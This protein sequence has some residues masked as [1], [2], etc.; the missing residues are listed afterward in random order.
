M[1]RLTKALVLALALAALTGS[2]GSAEPS[3]IFSEDFDDG[4]WTSN[5][6]WTASPA[7]PSVAISGEQFASGPY[8][9]KIDA[10]NASGA[11]RGPSGLRTFDQP[12]ACTFNL[13][14]EAIPEEGIPWCL[15]DSSG[16]VVALIFLLPGGRVELTTWKA[17]GGY[18]K[19]AVPQPLSYGLWHSFR[20]TYDGSTQALF[21]DGAAGPCASVAL[22]F[23]AAPT[24]ISVG[25]FQL[26]H[27][28]TYYVD[29]ITIS[30][31]STQQGPPGRVYVQFCSDTSTGG[32][33][34]SQNP[35]KFPSADESY[36]SPTG[37]AARVMADAYREA[38]RDSLGNPLKITWYMN[39]GSIYSCGVDT[40]PVL[41]YE[42]LE[43]NHGE[44][45]ARWG[46]EMAFHYHTWA[47]TDPDGDG[48]YQ[49]NQTPTFLECLTDF[50]A[51]IAQLLLDRAFYPSSFRSGWNWMDA[52]WELYLDQLFPYRFE[53]R[54][55][56]QGWVPYHPGAEDYRVPGGLRGWEA[57][58]D[59]IP[60]YTQMEVDDTFMLALDGVDQVVT[61]YSHLKEADFPEQIA[62]S[63]AKFAAAHERYPQVEYE[64]LTA[65][66]C[67][68]KWR[69]GSDVTPPVISV[70]ASDSGEVRTAVFSTDEEIYQT[71]PYVARKGTDGVYSRIPCEPAGPNRWSVSY[72][73]GETLQIGVAVTDWF[74]NPAVEA[75]PVPLRLGKVA[76]RATSS[77]V[78]VQWETTLPATTRLECCLMPAGDTTVIQDTSPYSPHKATFAGVLPGRVYRIRLTAE[79][80]SG[81]RVTSSDLY[82]LTD[83]AGGSVVDNVDAGFSV[84]GS[85]TTG[86]TASGR[87]GADYRYATTSLS[88]ANR[89]EWTLTAPAAGLYRV[90]AW[91]SQG[92][93]RS[94]SAPYSVI[95]RGTEIAAT[96][97]QQT[98]GGQWNPLGTFPLD[99]GEVVLVR[100]TNRAPSGYVV[101]ADAVKLEQ[102]YPL[103]HGPG[104]AKLLPD[105]EAI[106]LSGLVVSAVFEDDFY[107]QAADRSAGIRVECIGV[108]EGDRV[109]VSGE[110]ITAEGERSIADP[111]VTLE[112]GGGPPRPLHVS[113][114]QARD[115]GNGPVTAGMLVRVCGKVTDLEEGFFSLDDG[116]GPP[117]FVE[118]AR[119]SQVPAIG[120]FAVVTGV[121]GALLRNGVAFPLIRPRG[122]SDLAIELP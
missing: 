6:Y 88:G 27:T 15:M 38:L 103:V 40:T 96:V 3:V 13:F 113:S 109:T 75:L 61:L 76:V 68:L 107:A 93:N 2:V 10:N 59:Y 18:V 108:S 99:A 102:G 35:I 114:A 55:F 78:D 118:T 97:N 29:D 92:S 14:V 24:R 122:P 46:D 58:F 22:P 5:P 87:Y 86:S 34:T 60:A 117:V 101:I 94:A 23:R 36:T 81:D 79:S 74:G 63:C 56:A 112:G 16:G 41:P 26:A 30:A 42:L 70:S 106:T 39:C 119:L 37:Q 28:G 64:F 80:E 90:F 65:R 33:A 17:G 7:D 121:Q 100:L 89:A 19:S 85:W 31:E 44:A 53:G 71:Q 105:G 111:V 9:L 4:D 66:E 25:N 91:W 21:L 50:D 69:K 54:W 47:W 48:V 98:M 116:S 1:P 51:T 45:I 120:A 32:L 8:S 72:K 62:A 12:F 52:P 82:V 49:W 110:L 83:L 73:P 20:V 11:I 115:E 67:M 43:D 104:L 57:F 84:A 77:T 95:W